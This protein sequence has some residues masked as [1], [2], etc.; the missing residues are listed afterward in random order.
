MGRSLRA[1]GAAAAATA[2]ML[3]H[4]ASLSGLDQFS[5]SAHCEHCTD[6]AGNDATDPAQDATPA[7]DDSTVDSP[8][9]ETPPLDSPAGSGDDTVY[10]EGYPDAQPDAEPMDAPPGVDAGPKADA[11]H[12]AGQETSDGGA[13]DAASD[14]P[15][16]TSSSCHGCC[17][18]GGLCAG[19]GLTAACGTSGAACEDCSSYSLVCSAGA[20]VTPVPDA[21][22]GPATCM[23]TT[24][25]NLCVPYFIQC[26]KPDQ[27]CGCALLFPP[28]SCN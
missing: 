5:S 14:A 4:C 10:V 1:K 15:S 13:H 27:T 18:A 22:T 24:C 3:A 19:G 17:T 23:P 11:G 26:C 9:I 21:S 12:D 2:L 16:C 6:E 28:G 20:C 7:A 25:A 8:G